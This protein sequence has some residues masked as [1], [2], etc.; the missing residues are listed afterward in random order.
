MINKFGERLHTARKMAGLSLE[1]LANKAGSIV[2]KQAISKYEKGQINPGSDVLLALVKALGVKADYFFRTS[3]V[4]I[5][6]IEFRKR[7]KLT[8]SEEDR[9]KYQT[10]DFLQKYIEIED[11]LNIRY[12]FMNPVINNRISNYQDIENAAG[13]IRKKWNLGE[14]P[15]PHLIEM[16]ED[17]G[18]KIFEV[19][20]SPLFDG[21]SCFIE[22]MNI[23]VIAIFENSDLVRKRFTVAHELGHLLLNF[24]DVREITPEKLCHAFA[25]ALLLPKEIMLKYI[26]K[27]R[28]KITEWE[29]KKLKG[30]FGVS[31][32]AIM[33]RAC[34]LKIISENTYLQFN[35]HVNKHGWKKKE[36]GEYV[37]KEKA[38][39]FKQLVLYAAAEQ[40]ISSSKAAEL[41]NISSPEFQKELQIVS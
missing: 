2:S 24:S 30:V 13:E 12:P 41:L 28:D 32:Q 5:A 19:E 33:A 38:N 11:I 37:G 7:S 9:I 29:L 6:G 1:A 10:I 15:V 34:H 20:A 18:F 27:Q 17:K 36:P 22:D 40:I 26:G 3:K 14:G 23:P 16:L 25:G 35:I 21:F 31:M 4:S 8:K 39:R